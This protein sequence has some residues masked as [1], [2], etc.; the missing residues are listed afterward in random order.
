[1]KT[2][3]DGF[4]RP[5]LWLFVGLAWLAAT[6]TSAVLYFVAPNPGGHPD[7]ARGLL[8]SGIG[9]SYWVALA[10][11]IA[12]V[13]RRFPVRPPN[14]VAVGVHAALAIASAI[15]HTLALMALGR[16]FGYGLDE[17]PL[18][19]WRNILTYAGLPDLFVYGAI[20]AVIT[21]M[22]SA[23][24]MR[25][26]ETQ[27]AL[28]S[29]ELASARLE[30]LL[31]QLQ[32]HFVLNTLNTVAI[33]IREAATPDA[34]EVVLNL[35]ALLQVMLSNTSQQEHALEDEIAFLERYL[36]I[37]KVRFGERLETSIDIAEGVDGAA[38]PR[39]VLQPLVENALR[40]GIG[41]SANGGRVTIIAR[42]TDNHLWLQVSD[43][44]AG[45]PCT[46]ERGIGLANVQRR[47]YHL[48]GRDC[49][50]AI[51]SDPTKGTAATILLPFRL[52]TSET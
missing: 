37:A 47:L 29:A 23:A 52:H 49:A 22:D 26:R 42:H 31:L 44:G 19:M 5:D 27:A 20:V 39:Y 34:L 16:A 25:E 14:R 32:P 38:V 11:L 45:V 2:K 10:P 35:G 15:L 33:L 18:T 41:R 28:L 8:E 40:H 3:V 13:M 4:S 7:L 21:A 46:T 48:Y 43:N 17:S 6:V 12:M 30:A 9:W 50:L 51:D 1:M 36:S 24:E